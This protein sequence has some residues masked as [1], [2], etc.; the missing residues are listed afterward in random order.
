MVAQAFL[1]SGITLEAGKYADNLKG[2][3]QYLLETVE[4]T[5][6]SAK[7]I[8]EVRGTQIQTKLAYLFSYNS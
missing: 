6:K 3:L 4:N 8:T 7:Y 2:A 1:R 5:P